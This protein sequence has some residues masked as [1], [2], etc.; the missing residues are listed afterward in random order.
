MVS[1]KTKPSFHEVPHVE[2]LDAEQLWF[3][4]TDSKRIDEENR[5]TLRLMHKDTPIDEI[6]QQMYENKLKNMQN[7]IGANILQSLTDN[8]NLGSDSPENKNKEITLK[9]NAYRFSVLLQI[10]FVFIN[11]C[12]ACLRHICWIQFYLL[13]SKRYGL[14][15]RQSPRLPILF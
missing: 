7:K 11:I 3:S 10:Q 13:R 5:D 8:L 2:D 12:C 9:S 4:K 15:D 6:E 14:Q 1:F